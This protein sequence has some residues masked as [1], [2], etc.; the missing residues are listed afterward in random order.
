MD[1]QDIVSTLIAFALGFALMLVVDRRFAGRER[2]ILWLAFSSH[3]LAALAMVWITVEILG[4][5]DIR[6]YYM[7]G[8][9]LA[10][11]IRADIV[12]VL[13][14]VVRMIFHDRVP[15]PVP[16]HGQGSATGAMFGL[17]SLTFL[18]IG[19]S[20]YGACMAISMA[21]FFARVLIFRVM[22]DYVESHERVPVA[23]ACLLVP[24]VSF[25]CSGLL[26]ESFAFCGLALLFA[27]VSGLMQRRAPLRPILA[28]IAGAALA[29]VV[30]PYV[31]MPASIGIGAWLYASL[32]RS[33]S[34]LR[35]VWALP[36]TAAFGM[37]MVLAIGEVFPRFAFA[38]LPE[39]T[40]AI[41]TM[42]QYRTTATSTIV[43]FD[44]MDVA[45][46]RGFAAQ[47]VYAPLAVLTALFRP[48]VFDVKNA[49]MAVN[50]AEA[51]LFA[52]FFGLAFLRN[53]V[54]RL[55]QAIF[56]RPILAF[57]TLFVIGMSLGVGMVVSNLGSI[58]RYH[59]PM[60]PFFAVALALTY[61]RLER[62]AS[63]ERARNSELR[64]RSRLA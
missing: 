54:R 21:C 22:C 45:P 35:S 42:Y 62:V 7:F 61:R 6:A 34:P 44:P 53:G 12:N 37:V 36:L 64:L 13:P 48:A 2:L 32:T 52:L 25:W 33:G 26:K 51:T 16:V 30:K 31:L 17:A 41:Q 10:D 23:V 14:D 8:A 5:G 63:D 49:Q 1:L 3:V 24:S 43:L 40:L 28:V 9:P 15:L 38:N 56:E 4:G 39:E 47:L 18:L 19:N 55:L 29:G 11:A 57:C 58:S 20:L 50:A 60:M 27:G 46:E 59:T